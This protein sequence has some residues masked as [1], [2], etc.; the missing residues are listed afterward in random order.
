MAPPDGTEAVPTLA[1]VGDIDVKIHG[2]LRSGTN[3]LSA[4]VTANFAAIV[5]GP[6]DV[7]WKHGPI[8]RGA[9]CHVLVTKDPY[10]W[11]VSFKR[12]EEL[13]D[14]SA[15]LRSVAEFVESPL[16]HP[17]FATTWSASDPLDAWNRAHRS[18]LDALP[19]HHGVAIRFEDL[20]ADA[21]VTLGRLGSA[22]D[23]VPERE[24]FVDVLERADN[25][26][27]RR[28]RAPLDVDGYR[29]ERFMEEFDDAA[30]AALRAR[31]DHEVTARLGYCVR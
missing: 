8:Q 12:W 21:G 27:T 22:L 9:R 14:R 19:A 17:R 20:L 1:A 26:P 3:Y 25:W 30:L 5:H 23:L 7:G 4:L 2:A 24:P 15:T 31:L 18:W 10:S 13:H 29:A 11:V 28:P 6:D 16:S